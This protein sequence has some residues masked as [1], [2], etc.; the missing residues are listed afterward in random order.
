M[1][2]ISVAMLAIADLA[3]TLG[4]APMTKYEGCWE[5][6]VDDN[7]WIAIN[8]HGD[9]KK[10]SKGPNVKPY[11]CYVE[12]NGFPAGLLNPY[13]GAIA[14]GIVA[15]EDAFISALQKAIERAR[16]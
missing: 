2:Q 8:G 12:F 10:C 1:E 16:L 7:W 15:N 9:D 4:A 3:I 11:C 13:G 14:A 6:Q 5:H